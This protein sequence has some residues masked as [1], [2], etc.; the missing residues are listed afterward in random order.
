VSLA[1]VLVD[2]VLE[3]PHLQVCQPGQLVDRWVPDHPGL[4][5]IVGSGPRAVDVSHSPGAVRVLTPEQDDA[6]VEE[7]LARPYLKRLFVAQRPKSGMASKRIPWQREALPLLDK[8]P[9]RLYVARPTAGSWTYVDLTSA[10]PSLYG[11]LTLDMRYRPE[12]A[13]V[14]VGR[15]DLLDVAETLA[16]KPMHRTLGGILRSR[17]MR[18]REAGGKTKTYNTIGWSTFLCPDLWGV[19]MD[20]LHAVAAEAER[21][22]AVLW[23][24]DGGIMPTEQAAGFSA[25]CRDTWQLETHDRLAGD[26]IVWGLKHWSV[27]NVQT[28]QPRKRQLREERHLIEPSLSVRRTLIRVR[29]KRLALGNIRS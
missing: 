28:L 17:E 13:T 23:D 7:E 18:V 2:E 10:Y 5:L 14:S 29:E 19:I 12:S 27:G 24:T 26:T 6:F 21:R 1:K 9:P 25:W 16:W 22:G 8:L 11:P 20:S 3:R 15:F 4:R